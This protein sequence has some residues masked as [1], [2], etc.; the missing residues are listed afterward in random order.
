MIFR[1]Q[2]Q[3]ITEYLNLNK[4]II[5]YGPRQV[6][7]STLVKKFLTK[8]PKSSYLDGEEFKT[9]EMLDKPTIQ[10]LKDYFS[11]LDLLIIDEA[12]KI[13]NIGST[14]KLLKDHIPNLKMI[15]TGSSSFDL[16]P[17]AAWTCSKRPMGHDESSLSEPLTGR[18]ITLKMYPV[19]LLELDKKSNRLEI[20]DKIDEFLVFGMYPE[21][22]ATPQ[23][24]KE[25]MLVNLVESYLYKDLLNFQGILD[26]HILFKLL[27]LVALQIGSEVSYDKL[28]SLVGIDLMTVK[29]YLDILEKSFVIKVVS[30][31]SNNPKTEINKKKKIYFWD[32]GVRN[33]V[34][35]N[36][37]DLDKRSD[38]G[39]LWEN[40][41][42]MERLKTQ[43]YKQIYKQNYFWRSYSKQEIDW[44]E[45]KNGEIKAI[46]FKYS[47]KKQP[48]IPTQFAKN[49]DNY[50]FK[51]VSKNNWTELVK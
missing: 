45:L 13:P 31:F 26:R 35:D 12:Q 30:A 16:I 8:Y 5:L 9:Q 4:I 46:E 36:F 42:V 24:L 47:T 44:L 37:N 3:N 25:K 50:T 10:F 23:N 11:H 43:E 20:L 38:V 1:S 34:I 21:I 41:C 51:V 27:R 33:T 15:V 7:K 40:F 6:G 19:S 39:G 17:S 28:G 2:G 18:K 32:L 22:L 48:K 14:L 49:Y 29:R